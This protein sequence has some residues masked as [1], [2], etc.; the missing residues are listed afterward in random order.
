MEA[1]QKSPIIL[2]L[3]FQENWNSLL[4]DHQTLLSWYMVYNVWKLMNYREPDDLG[5]STLY[6]PVHS[7]KIRHAPHS[8]MSLSQFRALL[9]KNESHSIAFF[10]SAQASGKRLVLVVTGKGKDRDEPGPIPTP[11][12]VLRHQVPQWLM[13]SPLAQA[14]LQVTPAHVSHGGAGAYYVYLRRTR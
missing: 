11:R 12:G 5:F 13:L 10:L 6:C 7:C 4:A 9:F 1:T 3:I 14:V 8:Y 2:K